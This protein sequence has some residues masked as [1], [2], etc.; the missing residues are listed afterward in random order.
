LILSFFT[1]GVSKVI[2]FFNTDI[3]INN[4]PKGDL[5]TEVIS[6]DQKHSIRS[7]LVMEARQLTL[8]LEQN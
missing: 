2:G 5:M 7:Y 8:P 4:I 6:P 1:L 3:N